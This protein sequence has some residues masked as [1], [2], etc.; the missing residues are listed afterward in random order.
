M[1]RA[2]L[3][4]VLLPLCGCDDPRQLQQEFAA[5]RVKAV[6]ALGS[7]PPPCPD[8]TPAVDYPTCKSKA[9]KAIT[10]YEYK[11]GPYVED[12]MVAAGYRVRDDC[13][14]KWMPLGNFGECYERHSWLYS[15]GI[16]G[17]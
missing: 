5:C 14:A 2:V 16:L 12:C 13:I 17:E 3:V 15:L 4:A 11:H 9:A 7:M 6:D 1:R 10:E 8:E